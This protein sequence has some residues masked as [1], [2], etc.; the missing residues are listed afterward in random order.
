MN[1]RVWKQV[2][3]AMHTGTAKPDLVGHIKGTFPY[4]ILADAT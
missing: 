3:F 2:F 4:Q 1:K